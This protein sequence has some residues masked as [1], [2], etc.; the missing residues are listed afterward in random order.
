[1]LPRQPGGSSG[2]TTLTLG[3]QGEERESELTLSFPN[4]YNFFALFIIFRISHEE[5][6]VFVHCELCIN[7]AA[8]T[9]F[10]FLY[11]YSGC[12]APPPARLSQF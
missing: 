11:K 9:G 8:K 12:A 1:M 5:A 10:G 6:D 3:W 4:M 7:K 2:L